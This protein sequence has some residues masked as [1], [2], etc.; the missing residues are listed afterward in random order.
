TRALN[1]TISDP[2]FEARYLD[3]YRDGRVRALNNIY[4][5]G[6]TNCYLE[7]LES[8]EVKANL[9]TPIL[10]EGKLFG[11]LVAHQCS[12]PR[13]WQ[14][15]EIRW[16]TQIATQVGFAL[17]NAKVL[18]E[19]TT[20]Q[21]KAA[22]ERQWTNYFTDV[23]QYIRQSLKQD[24]ILGISV[25]E[26]RR[27]LECDRVVVYSLNQDNYGVVVA[28]SV[29]PGYTR[30]LNRT[31]SDPCFEA[32]Y[33][34][35]YR[36]GRVRAL[37]NIYE[38]GMT[39]CYIE[40][41]E[42]LEVKAN[43]VTPILNEGKLFGL[44]VA[45]QCS[46]PRDWQEYEI[47]WVAQIA[48]QVGFA[49]DNAKR[50]RRLNNQGVSTQLLNSFTLSIR[51]RL[52]EPELL[53]TSVEQACNIMKLDRAIVFQFDADWNGT[54]VAESVVRGYPRALRFQ[55]KD[56]CFAR[57]YAEKYR[58]GRVNAIAN[59]E[60]ANLTD[61]YRKQLESLAVKASLVAP[62]LQDE[63]LFG[64]FIGHQCS[65]PR[66]WKQSE[67]ELFAQL[68][69]QLGLAL[70]RGKL[71]EELSQTQQIQRNEAN[72]Q[73]P[74][75]QS[76]QQQGWELVPRNQAALSN[77]KGKISHQSTAR[78]SLINEAKEEMSHKAEGKATDNRELQEQPTD[79]ETIGQAKNTQLK[80]DINAA[81]KAISEAVEKVEGLNQSQQNLSQMVSLLKDM[82]KKM[83]ISEVRHI[84]PAQSPMEEI[85]VEANEVTLR[86]R[87]P[88]NSKVNEITEQSE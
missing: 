30:A 3:K 6:M 74:E 25:E 59:I 75:L 83:D 70:E 32:R 13:E 66:S 42:S 1:R 78:S 22:K 62:I 86:P 73:Q 9:V 79:G 68:A 58:Q 50:L 84:I 53:K 69:L 85:T 44:L 19:S 10:N 23:V 49:L 2:C 77:I 16:V 65:Q 34:D 54:V 35:K 55:I 7:Q 48:T 29:A 67:I 20:Q 31:I 43:L 64:L 47:R 37:N 56:P 15:Y 41:L 18:V 81:Q 52:N 4:E 5:A 72:Q 36:D 46:Q 45:H 71:R 17:D 14:E 26:V 40:Q 28:E 38:A 8:L 51:E 61:C 57:D 33:L 82:K 80:N 21:A 11:L 24:D 12:Q 39:N 88:P 27:V 63:V 60:R 76:H 87:N